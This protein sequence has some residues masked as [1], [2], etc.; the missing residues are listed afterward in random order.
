MVLDR[1]LDRGAVAPGTGNRRA[2]PLNAAPPLHDSAVKRDILAAK[3]T[4]VGEASKNGRRFVGPPGRSRRVIQSRIGQKFRGGAERRGLAPAAEPGA[5]SRVTPAWHRTR[6][7]ESARQAIWRR[8]LSLRRLRPAAVR[9]RQQIQQRHRLAELLSTA[10]GSDRD[11]N[12]PELL[13]EPHRG[14]LPP[15]RRTSRACLRRWA[16]SDR[17]AVLHERRVARL[18]CWRD[19][20]GVGQGRKAVAGSCAA[21]YTASRP[22]SPVRMRSASSTVKTKIL[23]SP[24]LSVF[25]ACWMASTARG[26]SAS[27]STTSILTLCRKSMTYSAPR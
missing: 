25:A 4:A 16:G 6:R 10:R 11:R 22:R 1:A 23:P 2:H 20:A 12:R 17:A 3:S 15:L 5:V 7:H 13:H 24:I 14:A 26:A 27:S 19:T 18:S 8:D 21:G 9:R